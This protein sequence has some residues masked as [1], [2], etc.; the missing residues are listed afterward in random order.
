[1]VRPWPDPLRHLHTSRRSPIITCPALN[2]IVYA[3]DTQQFSAIHDI[4][5]TPGLT[6]LD[7][8]LERWFAENDLLL[9]MI[10]N[11]AQL[12]NERGHGRKR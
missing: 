2:I 5:A 3:D 12:D 9:M 1:M 11:S 10:G 6:T 7:P 4:R 8:R